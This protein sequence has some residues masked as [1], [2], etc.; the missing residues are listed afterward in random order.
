LSFQDGTAVVE[1][2]IAI[3]YYHGIELGRDIGR[4]SLDL[5]TTCLEH[6]VT[7]IIGF[8]KVNDWRKR[9]SATASR[10]QQSTYLHI[11]GCAQLICGIC[12][13][14]RTHIGF[15][16]QSSAIVQVFEG[17]KQ[18]DWIRNKVL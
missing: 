1:R 17:Q 16:L 10:K 8:N 11:H 14:D 7:K 9:H 4:S 12:G 2:T 5:I 18:L 6:K 15:D 13:E 3:V